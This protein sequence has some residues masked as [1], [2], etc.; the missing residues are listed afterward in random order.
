MQF[1]I[2]FTGLSG[3]GKSTLAYAVQRDLSESGV[4]AF[5]L[6][7]DVLRTGLNS[8]LSFS[9][10][11]RAE[12]VRR[13]GEVAKLMTSAGV[14]VLVALISPYR[15]DRDR[16]RKLFAP[17]QFIEVF[18]DAPLQTCIQRD[19]KGLYAK[20]QRGEVH[21]MTAM[22]SPYEAPLKPDLHLHTDL[23]SLEQCLAQIKSLVTHSA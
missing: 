1:C 15:A 21:D 7:G 16:V 20:A 2:W 9:P 6:D 23:A 18:V 17:E 19:V 22:T 8:D 4:N 11:D 14:T 3:A 12:N 13:V 10:E 5:V